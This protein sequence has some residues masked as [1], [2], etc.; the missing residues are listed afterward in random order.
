MFATIGILIIIILS[1]AHFFLKVKPLMAFA[2][3]VSAIISLVIAM[4]YYELAAWMLISRGFGGAWSQAGCFIAL[5][6]FSFALLRTLA[7]YFMKT[8]ITFAPLPTHIIALVSG[9][10]FAMVVSGTLLITLAMAPVSPKWPYARFDDGAAI[11]ASTVKNHGASLLKL[12]EFAAGLFGMISKGSMSSSKSF[13]VYHADFIDQLHLNKL[14]AKEEVLTICGTEAISIPEKNA[15]RLQNDNRTIVR[16]ALKNGDV[17]DGGASDE[18]GKTSFTLSQ[19]RLICKN[20]A[21]AG[22]TLGSGIAI[23][24]FK[25][26][27]KTKAKKTDTDMA[28]LDEIISVPRKDFNKRKF[29]SFDLA[30][31]VPNGMQPVLLQFKQNAVVDLPKTV[32]ST[33]DIETELN[34]G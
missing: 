34:A 11:T 17:K 2:M 12:D 28:K 15:V 20:K 23:Y 33:D 16:M 4:S 7:D 25:Y 22:T 21:E 10:I 1:L 8:G 18:N 24:P 27:A 14:K 31:D 13:S 19:V 26:L 30:F 3:I 32:T 6:I 9:F 29:A 5:F